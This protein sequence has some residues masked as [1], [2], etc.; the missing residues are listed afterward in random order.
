MDELSIGYSPA[1]E[2][3]DFQCRSRQPLKMAPGK[4][5]VER[6]VLAFREVF[7]VQ[8]RFKVRLKKNIPIG[9][10]LG[11]GS[12]DAAAALLGCAWLTGK[13]K[14]RGP[15]RNK[16]FD[17]AKR[18][19]ADVAFFL[20]G[21][22]CVGTGLGER[23]APIKG[24]PASFVLIFP[25]F[26]I[27]TVEVYRGLSMPLTNHQSIRKIKRFLSSQTSSQAWASHLFNRLEEV[28]IPRYPVLQD[29]KDQLISAGC[30]AALMSGSG[31]SVFGVVSSPRQGKKILN[32][33]R[34]KGA[35]AWL[36]HSIIKH[37]VK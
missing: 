2:G 23:L 1:G 8:G 35:Q 11:G 4:N 28:A 24:S 30:S 12:A 15:D 10:G 6:A 33:F 17:L 21:G 34:R 13:A 16:L 32:Q 3:L 29:I 31:S 7:P 14:R 27:S 9:A 25:G 22:T 19:G 26:P 20:Q 18:L 36:V 37:P 5:L